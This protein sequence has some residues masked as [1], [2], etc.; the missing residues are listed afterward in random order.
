MNDMAGRLESIL[1]DEQAMSQI[2]DLVKSLRG[3][4]SNGADE[5]SGE[6]DTCTN[7]ESNGPFTQDQTTMDEMGNMSNLGNMANLGAAMSMLNGMMNN[8]QP[9]PAVELIR[10]LRPFLSD[11]RQ[12]KAKEAMKLLKVAEILPI[13]Q[14]SGILNGFLGGEDD[15]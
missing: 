7:C 11:K 5:M 10:A 15:E 13:V 12:K 1:G 6:Q 14:N 2:M 9:D 4:N 8:S 3:D